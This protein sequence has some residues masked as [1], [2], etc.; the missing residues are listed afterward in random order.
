VRDHGA[1][2]RAP[3]RGM[4]AH[5]AV[6]AQSVTSASCTL[7]RLHKLRVPHRGRTR[8]GH[9]REPAVESWQASPSRSGPDR[10]LLYLDP[11]HVQRVEMGREEPGRSAEHRAGQS[12]VLHGAG[13]RSAPRRTGQD[14]DSEGTLQRCSTAAGPSGS[15]AGR[16]PGRPRG[17]GENRMP[18]LQSDCEAGGCCSKYVAD[19]SRLRAFIKER[20]R[21]KRSHS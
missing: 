9:A 21:H 11:I 17:C 6:H 1:A 7:H 12:G 18:V 10:R 4:P 15:L 14:Q 13:C 2:G 5:K 19:Q 3:S 20:E 16:V 8:R